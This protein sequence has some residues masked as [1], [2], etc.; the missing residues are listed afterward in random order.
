MGGRLNLKKVV[1]LEF[2]TFDLAIILVLLFSNLVFLEDSVNN[3]LIA[4]AILSL[5]FFRFLKPGI[6]FNK[7]LLFIV[8]IVTFITVVTL[9]LNKISLIVLLILYLIA[10]SNAKLINIDLYIDLSIFCFL[11][12]ISCYFLFGLNVD[13]DTTIWRPLEGKSYARMSL[14]YYH[15][16]QAMLKWLVIVMAMFSRGVSK[17]SIIKIIPILVITYL[18]YS[19]TV[20]RTSTIIILMICLLFFIFR[21][22]LHIILSK[23]WIEILALSPVLFTIISLLMVRMTE[24]TWFNNLLSGRLVIYNN[25]LQ[26]YGITLLGSPEIENLMFDNAFLHMLFGKG[27]IFSIVY[28]FLFYKIVKGANY[29]T[30]REFLII[31]SF[32]CV[33]IMETMLLKFE[34]LILLIIML[35]REKD[36]LLVPYNLNKKKKVFRKISISR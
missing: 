1:N 32:L 9:Q 19:V 8:F 4:I 25:A 28:F 21:N 23:R 16:N 30:F 5:S 35:Y 22:K 18:L 24:I 33:G 17:K 29:I 11:L 12:I 10:R 15:S 20:S 3:M 7:I 6:T 14:G 26:T 34:I 27:I 36:E 2:K 31:L 13:Y